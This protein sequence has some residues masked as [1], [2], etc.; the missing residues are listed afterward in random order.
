LLPQQTP[1]ALAN[2]LTAVIEGRIRQYVRTEFAVK[3]TDHWPAQW[4]VL[5][6]VLLKEKDLN[7]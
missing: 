7:A 3:P 2:L 6:Q 1:T 4:A 5:S